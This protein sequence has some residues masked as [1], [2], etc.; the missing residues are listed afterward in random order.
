M[1][2]SLDK[3]KVLLGITSSDED[4]ALQFILDDVAE[5][6]LNYCNIAELP[7]GLENTCYRMAIDIYR[8][9]GVGTSQAP[10]DVTSIKEGDTS[11]NFA[12]A[13]ADTVFATSLLKEYK[14]QLNR[15][16]KLGGSTCLL[17]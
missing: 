16:R 10:G 8:A 7:A 12:K 17:S 2:L 4:I 11:V 15:Y 3:L 13:A 1:T 6:V 9:E 5:T 14:I